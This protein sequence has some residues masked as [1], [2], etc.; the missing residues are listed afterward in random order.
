MDLEDRRDLVVGICNTTV[1]TSDREKEASDSRLD[2]TFQVVLGDVVVEEEVTVSG[3]GVGG[4]DVDAVARL[5][6][7]Q[8][9]ERF[10]V[11]KRIRGLIGAEIGRVNL[12]GGVTSD[13]RTER[14]SGWPSE[15][16]EGIARG[17]GADHSF[18]EGHDRGEKLLDRAQPG[19]RGKF[20]G[21][22]QGK[23]TFR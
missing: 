4:I 20:R 15:T 12:L 22:T 11:S 23:A 5:Q 9:F 16:L 21:T 19:R 3:P 10:P 7:L 18:A 1:S 6:G 13:S 14:G 17:R 8:G 2:L